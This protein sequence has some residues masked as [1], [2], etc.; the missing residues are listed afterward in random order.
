MY[1]LSLWKKSTPV[2]NGRFGN[3]SSNLFLWSISY[4]SSIFHLEWR[5]IWSVSRSLLNFSCSWLRIL[6]QFPMLVFVRIIALYLM[7]LCKQRNQVLINSSSTTSHIHFSKIFGFRLY[8]INCNHFIRFIFI[9]ISVVCWKIA[10]P[11]FWVQILIS[12]FSSFFILCIEHSWS[13]AEAMVN[14]SW[15]KI[16]GNESVAAKLWRRE[17]WFI[18]QLAKYF[19]TNLAS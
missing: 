1:D 6:L 9:S 5:W 13:K 8:S 2:K 12:S 18:W 17:K 3:P 16:L 4:S 14:W 10:F 19:Q 11:G 15:W 7:R